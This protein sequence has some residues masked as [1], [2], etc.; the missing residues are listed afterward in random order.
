TVAVAPRLPVASHGGRVPWPLPAL[1]PRRV[2]EPALKA[3]VPLAC[4]RELSSKLASMQLSARLPSA[5]AR[6]VLRSQ[7]T[8][9]ELP[10]SSPKAASSALSPKPAVEFAPAGSSRSRAS[11]LPLDWFHTGSTACPRLPCSVCPCAPAATPR[12][13]T[14]ESDSCARRVFMA[15]R[16]DPGQMAEVPP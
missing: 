16:I 5:L 4:A 11:I 9:R 14:R 6:P 15:C 12:A 2:L 1:R 10:A 13:R 8:P 3:A 7:N